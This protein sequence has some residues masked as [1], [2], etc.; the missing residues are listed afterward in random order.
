[1]ARAPVDSIT[2][3]S[4]Y[5]DPRRNP[6]A[7][8]YP[9]HGV[10][11]HYGVD[12][13]GSESTLVKAPEK[14]DILFAHVLE[15][16][17]VANNTAFPVPFGGFRAPFDG[18][19]PGVILGFGVSGRYHLLAHLGRIAGDAGVSVDEG[20]TIAAM[21]SHVGGSG[22]H[23]H[24]EVRAGAIDTPATRARDTVDP[25]V[26]IRNPGAPVASRSSS[27]ILLWLLVLYAVSRRR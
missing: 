7:P 9:S 4:G 16:P 14:M 5:L 27:S 8:G 25:M 11:P 13:V 6:G 12:L 20:Q 23:T 17:D 22:S 24:W 26:W 1:M 2:I 3:A 19:G 18:Y 15:D 21:S 10:G